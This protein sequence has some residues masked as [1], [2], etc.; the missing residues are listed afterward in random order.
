MN[1]N[2]LIILI[3]LAFYACT[4]SNKSE[5]NEEKAITEKVEESIENGVYFVTPKNGEVVKNPVKLVFGV[6]GMEVEPAGVAAEGK[7]HH[8]VAI[9][10]TFVEKGVVVPADSMS[11]HYGKGQ[12]ETELTLTPGKHTLTMQFADG[13]HQSYGE[14]WS[15]T[16]EI[17]VE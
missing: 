15:K 17:T 5:G 4:S 14:A 12:L 11:I 9:D 2:L 13:F 7:G 3:P 16:I 10:G 8:H 6:N 1:K